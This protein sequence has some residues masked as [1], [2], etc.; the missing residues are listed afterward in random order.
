M[1]AEQR[2]EQL[3]LDDGRV[4]ELIEEDRAELVAQRGAHSGRLAHNARRQDQLIRKIEN[5]HVALALLIGLDGTEERETAAVRINDIASHV[6]SPPHLLKLPA[7]LL[8]SLARSLD[9]VAVLGDLT[10]EV[11]DL[12]H[13]ARG[14]QSLVQVGGPRLDDLRHQIERTGLGKHGEIGVDADPHPVLGHDTLRERVIGQGHR[15]FVEALAHLRHFTRQQA[16][17]LAQAV[18]Q[19]PRRLAGKSQAQDRGRGQV[20]VIG[21]QPEHP[22]RHGLGLTRPGTRDDQEGAA[23]G[24]DHA[25]LLR[26]RRLRRVDDCLDL[27]RA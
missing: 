23:W 7:E 16:D 19:L 10:R 1:I 15:V 13:H 8:Q 20:R 2:R 6:V 27:H 26:R 5:T 9:R 25:Y 11:Q 22:H 12:T 24:L 14:T 17:T 18:A 4:L 3:H 21:Q